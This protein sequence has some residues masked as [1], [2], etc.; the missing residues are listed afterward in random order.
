VKL[1]ALIIIAVVIP[2][3]SLALAAYLRRRWLDRQAAQLDALIR[4]PRPIFVG[5]DEGLE[6]R[7]RARREIAAQVKQR[8]A[9]IAS[10]SSSASVLKIARK[11]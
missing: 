4:S 11:A 1:L 7:A 2:G 5:A 10:G 3:G 6:V 9:L 8:S